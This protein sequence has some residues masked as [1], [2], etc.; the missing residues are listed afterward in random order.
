LTKGEIFGDDLSVPTKEVCQILRA[1][2]TRMRE[3]CESKVKVVPMVSVECKENPMETFE[4]V[5]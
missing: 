1:I 5:N 2:V 4:I 3:K